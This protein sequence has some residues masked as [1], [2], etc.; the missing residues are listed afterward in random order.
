MF[1]S[2]CDRS[3]KFY[4]VPYDK[5]QFIVRRRRWCGRFCSRKTELAVTALGVMGR[6]VPTNGQT[7]RQTD[8]QTE[9][10]P[11]HNGLVGSD[12]SPVGLFVVAFVSASKLSLILSD[13]CLLSRSTRC[14]LSPI[15]TA[16]ADAT[17]LDS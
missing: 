8:R 2:T 11:K 15:H 12:R 5:K 16:D 9:A 1:Y 4:V 7:D 17:Q 6:S 13:V 10:R 3:F 14:H